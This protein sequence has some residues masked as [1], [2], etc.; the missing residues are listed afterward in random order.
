MTVLDL[1]VLPIRI[2]VEERAL[3][4][5]T[6]MPALGIAPA[7]AQ[8]DPGTRKSES[9]SC[10]FGGRTRSSAISRSLTSLEMFPSGGRFSSIRPG[11]NPAPGVA[12]CT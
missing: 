11:S 4:A 2:P 1:L 3:A 7:F 10:D 9:E 8:S 6:V 12:V 5:N